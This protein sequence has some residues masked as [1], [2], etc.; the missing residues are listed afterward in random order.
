VKK[1]LPPDDLPFVHADSRVEKT[2]CIIWI[3]PIG[4]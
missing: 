4:F 3:V 2:D 1:L